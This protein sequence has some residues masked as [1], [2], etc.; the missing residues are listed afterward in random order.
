MN[1]RTDG[2]KLPGD[3]DG[4]AQQRRPTGGG[5]SGT[6]FRTL[7]AT[8]PGIEFGAVQWAAK[9][10]LVLHPNGKMG[11]MT[12]DTFMRLAL[13]DKIREVVKAEIARGK[14]IPPDIAAVIS[15]NAK[16]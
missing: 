1:A 3:N 12:L 9:R 13:L 15:G 16:G 6:D 14:A 11:A 8:V 10:C 2:W 7:K 4:A 5:Q